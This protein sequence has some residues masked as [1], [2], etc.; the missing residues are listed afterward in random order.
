MSKAEQMIKEFFEKDVKG[1]KAKDIEKSLAEFNKIF[2]KLLEE[3][4][5]EP[6]KEGSIVGDLVSKIKGP[7]AAV[8]FTA[9]TIAAQEGKIKDFEKSLLDVLKDNELDTAYIKKEMVNLKNIFKK[10]DQANA[11]LAKITPPD[12]LVSKPKVP[13]LVPRKRV[14]KE[15]EKE[16]YKMKLSKMAEEIILNAIMTKG[17][18][19]KTPDLSGDVTMAEVT[20][21]AKRIKDRFHKVEKIID[22]IIKSGGQIDKIIRDNE[23]N[24]AGEELVNLENGWEEGF[25]AFKV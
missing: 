16:G 18:D 14:E 15:I 4:K 2:I 5:K 24:Q 3:Y 20:T 23:P 8:L 17:A 7:L 10:M 11:E 9:L 6:S 25:K 19:D 13:V 21:Y 12:S 1:I 22:S